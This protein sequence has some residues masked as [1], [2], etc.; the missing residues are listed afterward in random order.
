M[1]FVTFL[2]AF[3]GVFIIAFMKG[4]F[5]GDFAAVGIPLIDHGYAE[6]WCAARA[7]LRRDGSRRAPRLLR[8][9]L[10]A[11]RAQLEQRLSIADFG[12]FRSRRKAIKG[13]RENSAG[14]SGAAGR[15]VELGE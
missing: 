5:G 2:V 1:D 15:S 4:A 3:A 11:M 8:K 12:H 14:F 7:T 13:W 6:R 10:C 9:P